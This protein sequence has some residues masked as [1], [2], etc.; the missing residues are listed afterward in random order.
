MLTDREQAIK[1]I[2]LE[3]LGGFSYAEHRHI[4]DQIDAEFIE[5][6]MVRMKKAQRR[7][8]WFASIYGV[9]LLTWLVTSVM[10][11]NNSRRSNILL[12]LQNLILLC[13]VMNTALTGGM[14]YFALQKRRMTYKIL[15]VLEGA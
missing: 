7:W 15:K 13:L 8:I 14:N 3:E 11:W 9:L 5:K 4:K 12:V 1:S 2:L 6:E 10:G